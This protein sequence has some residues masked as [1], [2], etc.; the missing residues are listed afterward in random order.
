MRHWQWDDSFREACVLFPKI[1]A[2]KNFSFYNNDD[3]Q[4]VNCRFQMKKIYI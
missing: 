2:S 1:I 3:N 4:P